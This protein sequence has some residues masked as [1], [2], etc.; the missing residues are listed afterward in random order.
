L[1]PISLR[2]A[3]PRDAELLT[4]LAHRS[5]RHWGYPE[6]WIEQWHDSLTITPQYIQTCRVI[7]AERGAGDVS[8]FSALAVQDSVATL[9][10][11]WVDPGRLAA[12]IGR[13][14]L[15]D[16]IEAA[17]ARGADRILIDSDPHAEAFYARMGAERAGEVRADMDGVRRVLPRMVMRVNR[18]G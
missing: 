1:I 6:A 18:N 11:L 5:K 9:D 10:H 7:V 12:G 3:H 14:L 17:S 13:V 15:T 16:A 8:G 2:P 4:E